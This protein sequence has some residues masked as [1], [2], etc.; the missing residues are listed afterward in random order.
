M[1]DENKTKTV[2]T[3]GDS[4]NTKA[5]TTTTTTRVVSPSSDSAPEAS[6]ASKPAS[7]LAAYETW[8]GSHTGLARNV[9]TTLYVA[10]Q[11]VPV[12]G[13]KICQKQEISTDIYLEDIN[14]LLTACWLCV[15]DA[16]EARDGA[17]GSDA[18]RLLVGGSAASVPRLRTL[19]EGERGEGGAADQLSEVRCAVLMLLWLLGRLKDR[20][21]WYLLLAD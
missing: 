17:G 19:E 16:T 7:L 15:M 4:K 11:L 9:E 14:L 6:S 12:R 1:A 10:P 3:D 8:V 21:V 13:F 2:E 18:V 5:A 20:G